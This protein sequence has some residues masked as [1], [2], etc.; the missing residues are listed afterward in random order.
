MVVVAVAV[1]VALVVSVCVCV[2]VCG[3]VRVGWLELGVCRALSLTQSML[4][5][6]L[7]WPSTRTV[8]LAPGSGRPEPGPRPNLTPSTN[9]TQPST[10]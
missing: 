5:C 9:P 1:A 10:D 6:L 8:A 3:G 2:C 4:T 7:L